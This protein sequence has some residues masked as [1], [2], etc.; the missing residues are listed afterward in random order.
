[1]SLGIIDQSRPI[2]YQLVHHSKQCREIVFPLKTGEKTKNKIEN[3]KI[4]HS[5][6]GIFSEKKKPFQKEGPNINYVIFNLVAS[7]SWVIKS[8]STSVE[9]F[10]S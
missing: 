3:T 7:I 6:I 4:S 1:M 2:F 9:N 8:A 10:S 5:K